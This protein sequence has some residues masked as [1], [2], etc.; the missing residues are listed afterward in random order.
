VSGLTPHNKPKAA[1]DLPDPERDAGRVRVQVQFIAGRGE[2]RLAQPCLERA[3]RLEGEFLPLAQGIGRG[4]TSGRIM[5]DACHDVPPTV[6]VG[7]SA[8]WRTTDRAMTTRSSTI[9]QARPSGWWCVH[10][11]HPFAYALC[12]EHRW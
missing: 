9:P 11:V 2:Q 10:R 3:P 5:G 1:A 8:R 6:L 4:I 7:R 12:R